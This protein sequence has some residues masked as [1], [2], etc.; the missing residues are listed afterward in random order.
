MDKTSWTLSKVGMDQTSDMDSTDDGKN[1]KYFKIPNFI[2]FLCF[3]TQ[4]QIIGV[5]NVNDP[6]GTCLEFSYEAHKKI[7]KKSP[8]RRFEIEGWKL[9]SR[10]NS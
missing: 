8:K 4:G 7:Y 2:I 3:K 5:S 9:N 1:R 6:G 10:I